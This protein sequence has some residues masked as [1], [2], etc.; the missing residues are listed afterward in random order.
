MLSGLQD[1]LQDGVQ[2]FWTRLFPLHTQCLS[3][4]PT[5]ITGMAPV[6]ARPS[7]GPSSVG[8]TDPISFQC[9]PGTSGA[10]VFPHFVEFGARAHSCCSRPLFWT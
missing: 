6:S 9:F 1:L 3:L 10:H 4:L 7:K 8:P 2:P 5:E